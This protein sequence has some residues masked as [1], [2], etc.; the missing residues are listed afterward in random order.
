MIAT[1]VMCVALVLIGHATPAAADWL[2]IPFAGITAAGSTGYFDPDDAV[3]R[4]KP[5]LGISVVRTW[6][7]F[8]LEGGLAFVPGF[9]SAGDDG[10]ITSS[11]VVT[12]TGSA[13]LNLPLLGRVQPYVAA[14]AGAVRV[15]IRDQADVF[16]VS[17]WKPALDAGAG[18][19]VRMTGRFSVRTR[20]TCA[21]YLMETAILR[22]ASAPRIWRSGARPP[23]LPSASGEYRAGKRCWFLKQLAYNPR[24]P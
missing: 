18:L 7:R 11:N 14:G 4:S 9:F 16:P 10:L 6:R 12:L 24:T 17:E 23:G 1:R 3:S 20:D 21:P 8:A 19:L 15:N 22:W 13:I 2:L 5:V